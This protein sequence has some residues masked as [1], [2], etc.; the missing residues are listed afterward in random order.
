MP[1]YLAQVLHGKR[2]LLLKEMMTAA[3]CSDDLLFRD[4]ASGF[5]ISGW[6]PVT[7]NTSA[8]LRPPQMSLA[9]LK[10]LAPG[11]NKTVFS[12]LSSSSVHYRI[13]RPQHH[14]ALW[15]PAGREDSLD[16]Y[17]LL[18]DFSFSTILNS[19]CWATVFKLELCNDCKPFR[20]FLITCLEFECGV[21]LQDFQLLLRLNLA[22]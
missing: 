20:M 22:S 12:K 14:Y 9:S 6:M 18:A 16:E 2:I 5:R 4:I 13:L 17:F 3:G 15:D 21:F 7:G 19:R 10:I 11:L 1:D 8:K